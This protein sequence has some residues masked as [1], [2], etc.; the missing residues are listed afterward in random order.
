MHNYSRQ[1]FKKESFWSNVYFLFSQPRP[2]I[3]PQT[4]NMTILKALHTIRMIKII[5]LILLIAENG[6]HKPFL[7]VF[8]AWDRL[9]KLF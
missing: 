6:Q 5:Y 2:M 9:N 8:S 7:V 1:Y 3:A 4:P